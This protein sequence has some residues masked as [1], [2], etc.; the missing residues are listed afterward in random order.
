MSSYKKNSTVLKKIVGVSSMALCAYGL[1]IS[2]AQADLS[3]LADRFMKAVPQKIEKLEKKRAKELSRQNPLA[4]IVEG[5]ELILGLTKN[6][7]IFTDALFAVKRNDRL[8]YSLFELSASLD[9]PIDIDIQNKTVKGWFIKETNTIDWDIGNETLILNGKNIGYN[10]ESVFYDEINDDFFVDTQVIEGIFGFSLAPNIE[11]LTVE[12]VGGQPLP[13]E[14][15]LNRE[16]R[17][18]FLQQERAKPVLPEVKQEYELYTKPFVDV[19]LNASHVSNASGAKTTTTGHSLISAND[20]AYGGVKTFLSGDNNDFV[21]QFR[22]QWERE[23]DF[24]EDFGVAGINRFQLGDIIAPS[25]N[26]LEGAGQELGFR[27]D[28]DDTV[29]NNDDQELTD[30]TQ[31]EG[32]IQPGW[33]IEL[34]NNNFL[35]DIQTAPADGRYLFENVPLNFG[36]NN[37]RLVFYGPQGQIVEETK[38]IQRRGNRLAIGQDTYSASISAQN[39]IT[40]DRTPFDSEDAGT[41][42]AVIAY[43]RGLTDDYSGSLGLIYEQTSGVNNVQ[44][45]AGL[46]AYRDSGIYEVNVAA[47]TD[48][49][50]ALETSVLTDFMGQSVRINNN[51]NTS[52]FDTLNED[53]NNII[54]QNQASIRGRVTPTINYNLS[55][56]Y[57]QTSDDDYSFDSDVSLVKKLR[58]GNIGATYSFLDREAGDDAFTNHSVSLNGTYSLFPYFLR[59]RVNYDISPEAEVRS[60]FASANRRINKNLSFQGEVEVQ[61]NADL[62][63]GRLRLNYKND[64]VFISPDIRFDTDDNFRAL[65]SMRFGLG[66]DPYSDRYAVSSDRVTSRGG[67]SARAFLDEDGDGLWDFYEEPL[68]EI[69]VKAVQTNRKVTTG[70]DGVAFMANITEDSYTDIILDPDSFPDPYFVSTNPGNSMRIRSG[71]ITPMTFPVVVSGE[72]DGVVSA[73]DNNGGLRPVRK[74]PIHLVNMDGQII[75]T[76]NTAYDGFYVMGNIVPGRYKLILDSNR[77]DDLSMVEVE[78]KG[79]D[80]KPDGTIFFDENFISVT[81]DIAPAD[82]NKYLIS[83]K[84]KPKKQGVVVLEL[85]RYNSQLMTGVKWIDY[86]NRYTSLLGGLDMIRG[87]QALN[88][89]KGDNKFGLHLGPVVNISEAEKICDQIRESGEPCTLR[90]IDLL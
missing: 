44:A 60:Y 37:F 10:Q 25:L 33:D 85:G 12:I 19:Q 15:R 88:K 8:F 79:F 43:E 55:A 36:E 23:A 21:N 90:A 39:R 14:Q 22:F 35:V 64:Y 69:D 42:R 30:I 16:E 77:L 56:D 52:D 18:A 66:D 65:V 13:V 48:G 20:L 46:T 71:R 27:I 1:N 82:Y 75:Q 50:V 89:N 70:D 61:P 63:E 31:F 53:G 74:M 47:E 73:F 57:L 28:K 80:F 41:P 59:G 83:L 32:D 34:Y 81:R 67:V 78:P 17:K 11:R 2:I 6:K 76:V 86:R 40:Y 68:G 3:D 62:T 29:R 72:V 87:L 54:I 9:F 4:R 49:G 45:V 5:D 84:E 38:L 7:L 51:Y 24:G 26:I 58:R